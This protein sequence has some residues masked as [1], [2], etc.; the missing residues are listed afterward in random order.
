MTWLTKAVL[1]EEEK[2]C[3]VALALEL[4]NIRRQLDQLTEALS[5]LGD[6]QFFKLFSEDSEKGD[7]TE[8][9]VD[10]YQLTLQKRADAAEKEFR[11]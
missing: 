8:K 4:A 3:I 5:K 10:N 7:L 6:K 11:H 9:Q 1:T 2:R